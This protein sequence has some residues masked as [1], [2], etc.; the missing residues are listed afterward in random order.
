MGRSTDVDVISTAVRTPPAAS[1]ASDSSPLSGPTRMRP[2]TVSTAIS[3]SLPTFGSTTPRITASSGRY[4][5]ESASSRAP[6]VTSRGRMRCERSTM[7]LSGAIPLMTAWQSPTHSLPSPKSLR[8]T[9][10]RGRDIRRTA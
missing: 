7:G 8:K 9:M 1:Q 2:L 10:G 5:V 3:R 4:G 6:E